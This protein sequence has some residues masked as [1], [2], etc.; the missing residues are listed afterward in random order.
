MISSRSE[1]I[2]HIQRAIQMKGAVDKM[3]DRGES[4]FG[5]GTFPTC[6]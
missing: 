3:K 5:T 2:L 1:G 6:V 4:A